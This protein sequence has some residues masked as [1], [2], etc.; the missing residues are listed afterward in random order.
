MD[1]E[2]GRGHREPSALPLAMFVVAGRGRG[3]R[4]SAS[5]R[6]HAWD[7]HQTTGKRMAPQQM[8]ST[9]KRVSFQSL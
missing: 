6:A 1:L 7:P 5:G 9:R 2:W 4:V 3:V 8:R